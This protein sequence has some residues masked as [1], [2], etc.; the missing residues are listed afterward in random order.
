MT[1]DHRLSHLTADY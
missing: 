1:F